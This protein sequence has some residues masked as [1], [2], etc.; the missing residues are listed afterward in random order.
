MDIRAYTPTDET[1]VIELW[2]ATGLNINPLNDA[3]ADIALCTSTGH[4]EILIG[5]ED[6]ALIATIMVG[7]DGHRGWYYYLATT[8]DRQR[9]GLGRAMV[10]A[11]EA[12][13][14]ERG[15]DRKSTRLNSSH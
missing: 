11:G 5:E 2:Q 13:L 1:A 6:G 15:L 8:P 4:G 14:G 7:H 3:R 10:A 9:Q 12:W